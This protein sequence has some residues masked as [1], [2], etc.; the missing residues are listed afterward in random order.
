P[1][2]HPFTHHAQR[3]SAD[4]LPNPCFQGHFSDRSGELRPRQKV[5]RIHVPHEAL[6][7]DLLRHG[8]VA[9]AGAVALFLV[10]FPAEDLTSVT[11]FLELYVPT[12]KGSVSATVSGASEADFVGRVSQFGEPV[13]HRM[14]EALCC[15]RT[16]LDP[17]MSDNRTFLGDVLGSS[18]HRFL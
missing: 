7:V 16:R 12:S 1:E 18:A 10:G 17:V 6:S 11:Y 4:V 5:P 9:P 13:D 14:V 8:H 3:A 15:F 2:G